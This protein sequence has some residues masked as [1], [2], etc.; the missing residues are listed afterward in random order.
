M[1]LLS[2]SFAAFAIITL[3]VAVRSQSYP[4]IKF[5]KNDP[6]KDLH[7]NSF[8]PLKDVENSNLRCITNI[9]SEW[10]NVT[11]IDRRGSGD[12]IPLM[13]ESAPNTSCFY[14]NYTRG[15]HCG[16]NIKYRNGNESGGLFQCNIK[17]GM[18]SLYVYIGTRGNAYL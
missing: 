4:K 1:F 13:D 10:C 18:K 3:P 14:T 16:M 7:N 11:W 5:C 6:C 8:I 17:G 15:Q 9:T 12:G 2:A